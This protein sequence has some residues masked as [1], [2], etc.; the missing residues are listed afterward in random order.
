MSPGPPGA[1]ATAGEGWAAATLERSLRGALLQ[2]TALWQMVMIGAVAVAPEAT[3]VRI[4]LIALHLGIAGLALALRAERLPL[5]PLSVVLSAMLVLEWAIADTVD[6]ALSFG[7]AW[8]CN[9]ANLIPGLL[10]RG[11]ELRWVSLLSGYMVPAGLAIVHP[12][13]MSTLVVP[14]IVT[15][16]AI[17]WVGRVGVRPL[18]EFARRVDDATEALLRRR[19]AARAASVAARQSA[20]EARTLHDTVINTLAAVANG[21]AAIDDVTTVRERCASDLATLVALTEHGVV[22]NGLRVDAAA[23]ACGI[24]VDRSGL[25]DDQLAEIASTIPAAV[26]HALQGVLTES[27]RN[28][29]KHAGTRTAVVHAA[30]ED[31]RLEFVVRDDGAGFDGELVPGRGLAESVFG[32]AADAG[33]EVHLRTQPGAGTELR[34]GY[35]IADGATAVVDDDSEQPEDYAD[36]VEGLRRRATFVWT[37]GVGAVGLVIE[38]VNRFGVLSPTYGML[39]VVALVAAITWRTGTRGGILGPI[40]TGFVVVSVPASFLLALAGTDFGRQDLILWQCLGASAPLIVLLV[41]GRSLTPMQIGAV[42]LLVAAASCA[43]AVRAASP[44]A[45]AVVLIGTAPPLGILAAWWRFCRTLDDLG[46]RAAAE[47]TL[48]AEAL[49][50]AAARRAA[51]ASRQRWRDA[52]LHRCQ[53]LLSGLAG[54]E[55]DPTDAAVQAACADEERYLRQVMLLDPGLYWSAARFAGALSLARTRQVPLTVRSGGIEVESEATA[56][57]FG[58]LLRATVATA[59]AQEAVT[60]SLFATQDGRLRFAVVAP[61]SAAAPLAWSAPP[62]WTANSERIGDVTMIEVV[63]ELPPPTVAAAPSW[64]ARASRAVG[65]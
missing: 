43:L 13:W 9:L 7:A 1:L 35:A 62:R 5:W 16:L 6:G 17:R 15:G 37:A 56:E 38:F 33:I 22:A 14:A 28:V 24:R 31:G 61:A 30:V 27:L 20:E 49:E 19:R 12:D 54:T 52:G 36:T 50:E 21:G 47:Q 18:R 2:G 44:E 39:L 42:A 55:L 23:A 3:P 11:K 65:A 40:A 26:V 25:D 58:Q 10:L 53:V 64:R 34:V 8:M 32:R 59:A 60:A 51:D 63:R 48:A 46:R 45:T 29:A 4:T 57:R 41:H